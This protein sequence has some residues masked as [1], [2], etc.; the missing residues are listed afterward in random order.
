MKDRNHFFKV[1]QEKWELLQEYD[2]GGIRV[3]FYRWE[4]NQIKNS[5]S[6][7]LETVE[8]ILAKYS[9]ENQLKKT[10]PITQDLEKYRESIQ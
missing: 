4:S 7:E 8:S 1:S 9:D 6:N 2:S 5:T 10:E 3:G